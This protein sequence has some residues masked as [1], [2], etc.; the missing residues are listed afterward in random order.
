MAKNLTTQQIEKIQIDEGL[1]YLNFGETG[2]TKLAPTRGGG[3]FN[4]TVTIRDVEFDGRA[5][6]TAGMQVIESQSA[7]LKVVCL[8]MSQEQLQLAIP[9]CQISGTGSAAI[10]KNPKTGLIPSSEYLKNVTMFAKLMDGKY[11]KITIYNAMHEGGFTAKAVQKAE[12]ELSLEFQAHYD[13]TVD[14]DG[15]IWEVKEVDSIVTTP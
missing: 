14:L 1:I 11:K 12:G 7:T 13:A 6:K 8:C 2:E 3:E 5:G 10:I 15:D 9:N 4:A